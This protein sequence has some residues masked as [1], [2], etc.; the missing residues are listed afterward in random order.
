MK[1]YNLPDKYSTL[2]VIPATVTKIN[3]TKVDLSIQLLGSPAKPL[4]LDVT[5]SSIARYVIATTP[6]P[7]HPDK[8]VI[9][10]PAFLLKHPCLR[11]GIPANYEDLPEDAAN[12]LL[13]PYK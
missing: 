8:L 4:L 7:A 1:A 5:A 10:T 2:Y 13:D 12:A 9:I 3:K 11:S 6:P